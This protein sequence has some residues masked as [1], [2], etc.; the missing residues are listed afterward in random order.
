MLTMAAGPPVAVP[1]GSPPTAAA[2]GV[3][4]SAEPLAPSLRPALFSLVLAQFL[5]SFAGTST[6]VG[7]TQIATDF[8]T[9]VQVIQTAI[10]L[11]TLTMAALMI[12]AS[13]L[14]D[15][16]G[17]KRCFAVGLLVYGAGALIACG[18]RIGG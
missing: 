4:E 15:I 3:S 6:N 10:T 18:V 7:I 5:C 13:K 12:P 16:V 1:S 17:R 11:F 14:T 8:G 9:S 2:P